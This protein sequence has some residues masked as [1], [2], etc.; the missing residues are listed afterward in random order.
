MGKRFI[1]RPMRVALLAALVGALSAMSV[2][3]ASAE[4]T[5]FTVNEFVPFSLTA[6]G[7]GDVIDVAGTLHVLIHF[8]FSD[9]GGATIKAHFQPQ[10]AMGVGRVSGATYQATG[11]TQSTDTDSGPGPQFEFTFVNNF[12]IVSHGTTANYMV[13]DTVHVTV[14]NNGEVTTVVENSSV[15]CRG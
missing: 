2:G 4:A 8:T 14:N 7:C 10:G 3:S 15:E 1:R 12:K 11:V 6:E 13:H 9:A 5:Q